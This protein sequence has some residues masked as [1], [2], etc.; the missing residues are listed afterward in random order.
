MSLDELVEAR[1]LAPCKIDTSKLLDRFDRVM[2]SGSGAN[3][4]PDDVDGFDRVGVV[5]PHLLI[6]VADEANDEIND[7]KS[8]LVTTMPVARLKML[9]ERDRCVPDVDGVAIAGFSDARLTCDPD[10]IGVND[11]PTKSE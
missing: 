1:C 10:G 11:D 8:V 5:L 9:G 2:P 6:S 3:V 4:L 7:F